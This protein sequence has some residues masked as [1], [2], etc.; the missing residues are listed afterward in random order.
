MQASAVIEMVCAAFSDVPRPKYTLAESAVAD[1]WGD[2]SVRFQEH[3]SSWEEIP[4]DQIARNTAAFCFLPP[5]SWRYYIPAYV[6]WSLRHVR[7]Y[8]TETPAHLIYTL[9]KNDNAS[10][11]RDSL[12]S[13]QRQAIFAFLSF[14]RGEYFDELDDKGHAL[15]ASHA[16]NAVCDC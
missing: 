14:W 11:F 13:Q 6:V 5:G 4:D 12:T 3:D 1:E 2:E 7:D 16:S 8:K 10:M 15:W 9:T